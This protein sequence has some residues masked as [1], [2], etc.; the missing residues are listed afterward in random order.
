MRCP[1]GEDPECPTGEY[2]SF[3]PCIVDDFLGQQS[4][5]SFTSFNSALPT[6]AAPKSEDIPMVDLPCGPRLKSL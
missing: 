1:S 4:L 5:T 3:V 2:V 6:L